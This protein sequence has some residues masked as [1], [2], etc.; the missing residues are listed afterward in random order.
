MPSEL[1]ICHQQNTLHTGPLFRILFYLWF[2]LLRSQAP[3]PRSPL[4][5]SLE[6][7]PT[8]LSCPQLLQTGPTKITCPCRQRTGT[9]HFCSHSTSH[10]SVP[11]A[12]APSSA[13]SFHP[14]HH[15]STVSW[16]HCVTECFC[17]LILCPLA[18]MPTSLRTVLFYLSSVQSIWL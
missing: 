7:T 3:P 4:R 9:S 6:L 10:H 12:S 17:W 1:M 5:L 15:D 13:D 16:I 8:G 2:S 11:P 14:Y 18:Q